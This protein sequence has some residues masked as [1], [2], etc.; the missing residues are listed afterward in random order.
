MDEKRFSAGQRLTLARPIPHFDC[1]HQGAGTV[2]EVKGTVKDRLVYFECDNCPWPGKQGNPPRHCS[3]DMPFVEE[4][5][6]Q[7]EDTHA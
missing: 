6:Q 3:H 2:I 4:A 5:L 1:E 7:E